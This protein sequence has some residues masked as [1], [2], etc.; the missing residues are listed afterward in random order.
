MVSTFATKSL[1]TK[2]S[3]ST[4]LGKKNSYPA[5]I[6]CDKGVSEE[7]LLYSTPNLLSSDCA[8]EMSL[9]SKTENKNITNFSETSRGMVSGSFRVGLLNLDKVK[10]RPHVPIK[11]N[12]NGKT[13]TDESSLVASKKIEEKKERFS[14]LNTTITPLDMRP[15][16]RIRF[17][18]G[19]KTK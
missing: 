2:T 4:S 11:Q 3:K 16:S 15:R 14:G 12:S 13:H 19:K 17:S 8:S 1:E 7:S 18:F 6:E 9:S 10:G 5:R